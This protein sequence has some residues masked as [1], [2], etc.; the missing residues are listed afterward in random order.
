MTMY[1]NLFKTRDWILCREDIWDSSQWKSDVFMERKNN[2]QKVRNAKATKLIPY[3]IVGLST[4]TKIISHWVRIPVNTKS[5]K[6][7][8]HQDEGRKYL[9]RQRT[10]LQS[11]W[12]LFVQ[13]NLHPSHVAISPCY[14]MRLLLLATYLG[15][16][17]NKLFPWISQTMCVIHS[18]LVKLVSMSLT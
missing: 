4:I 1:T 2:I 13:T 7:S 10:K 12:Q 16:L 14:S 5:T 18:I 9:S 8:S 11:I 15:N 6:D 3:Y 17:A